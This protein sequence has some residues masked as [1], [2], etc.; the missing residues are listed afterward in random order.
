[1]NQ[2][3]HTFAG[4]SVISLTPTSVHACDTSTTTCAPPQLSFSALRPTATIAVA[5]LKNKIILG[6]RGLGA[7]TNIWKLAMLVAISF[8]A[9]PATA[10]AQVDN[11]V[12]LLGG[13]MAV[14]HT[15][16]QNAPTSTN[17]LTIEFWV[18]LTGTTAEHGRPISKRG[19][20]SSGI[21]IQLTTSG[22]LRAELGGICDE[23]GPMIPFNEWHHCAVVWSG[24]A[25]TVKFYVDGRLSMQNSVLGTNLVLSGDALQFGEQCGRGM[26]GAMDNVRLW[27]IARTAAQISEMMSVQFTTQQAAQQNELVGS[28]SF[29][30]S[31]PLA[32][33]A[34][35]NPVG[36]L[37]GSASIGSE[38]LPTFDADGDGILD[39]QDNCVNI[40]N[41]SQADCDN[42]G[43]GDA[44]ELAV[45]NDSPYPGAVQWTVASGGNG[46]WYARYTVD[47][48]WEI[49]RIAAL[50]NGANLVSITSKEENDFIKTLLQPVV[51]TWWIGGYK[52]SDLSWH[53]MNGDAWNFTKWSSGEPN[54]GSSDQNLQIYSSDGSWNDHPSNL[55]AIHSVFEWESG[56]TTEFDCNNN[57]IPDSCEIANGGD[58]NNNGLLDA[59]E[60]A[61]HTATDCNN[62][63]IL[64]ACEIA[65]NTAGDCDGDGI[66][67]SCE[68][69]L[70]ALDA[71]LNG[72]PDGCEGDCNVN[73]QLDYLDIAAGAADCNGNL[74]IDSCEDGSGIYRNSGNLG[75][76]G[77][78]VPR[79]V[80][81]DTLPAAVTSVTLEVSARANLSA[82]NRF[83][84][85]K[86]NGGASTYLFQTTGTDCPSTANTYS[87]TFTASE[88]NTLTASGSLA[89]AFT[90]PGTV[91]ATLCGSDALLQVRLAYEQTF[92][93]CD[94]DGQRDFCAIASGLVKDCNRNGIPDSCDIATGFAKDC[95]RNEIP[96]ICDIASGLAPD[97]NS[98]G[99]PDSCDPDTDGDGI[100]DACDPCPNVAGPCNGCPLNVCGDCGTASDADGDGT[101]NCIDIDDDNDG[102][103]DSMDAFP[104]DASESVDTDG[105]GQGD[106]ADQDD[107]GDGTDDATDGCPFDA[108]KSAPGQCGC[109]N[110]DT[111]TDGDGVA[112]CV[113]NCVAVANP[114]QTDCDGNG[115]GEACETF[116]DCNANGIPDSC[117]LASGFAKDCNGNGKPDSCDLAV[118]G[119]PYPGA[120]LWTVASGGNGHWYG[121]DDQYT[122][123]WKQARSRATQLNGHLVSLTSTAEQTFVSQFVTSRGLGSY[124]VWLGAYRD[125]VSGTSPTQNWH[126]VTG[127]SWSFTA[128]RPDGQPTDFSGAIYLAATTVLAD[129]LRWVNSIEN[130]EP[131]NVRA[132]IEWSTSL[133]TESDCNANTI[134]DSCEI[135]NGG[136]CNNN[137]LLDA[138]ETFDHTTP[139]CNNNGVP[140][141][142]DIESR[143]ARDCDLNNVPDSCDIAAGALD[144][145]SDGRIDACNYAM[146]DFDL[147]NEVDSSDLSF[148][149]LFFGEEN[150]PFG[151]LDGSGVC[152]SADLSFCLLNFGPLE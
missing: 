14:P 16:A 132:V 100:I 27:S 1:M 88:F 53:W 69:A 65:N 106:N 94:N 98:N 10:L 24:L 56:L 72:V 137:G 109:G 51:G 38:S 120:V 127:E 25:K 15:D 9:A 33:A 77:S 114:S 66:L 76:I 141:S 64:D 7:K 63:G 55:A 3:S 97:C 143:F 35:K 139:D 121:I 117:D 62:N 12:L 150:P 22:Q 4:M 73:G 138:C 99:I 123:N 54:G 90:A 91:N 119:S 128:W 5:G 85:M 50:A 28:W 107:D 13:N 37:G 45:G 20:S 124:D 92:T 126:W 44:C 102:V 84:I 21:T 58:C 86:L 80:T 43:I 122:P 82:S 145:N 140:D 104:L 142:C 49:S 101:A 105:D 144:E 75:N 115:I 32:D 59:C 136:D 6:L 19:C 61:N 74:M 26:Y 118:S 36:G 149:L 23:S 110:P 71:N 41:P 48:S 57:T 152:D 30:G 96:D 67:N 87:R 34:A 42:D 68:I 146:G 18:R 134:P 135:A 130:H 83:L 8:G 39:A 95:N 131:G 133:P 29:E 111:D 52:A 47:A 89:V 103:V 129:Q 46:H 2:A 70:G 79:S 60:I 148:M 116:T 11:H 151:D 112:D 78:G 108:T 147:S 113:D 31:E 17:A 125:A 93:D 40:A 81:F